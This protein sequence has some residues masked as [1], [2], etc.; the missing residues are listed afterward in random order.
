M[1]CC[2]VFHTYVQAAGKKGIS[3]V[4]HC[5]EGFRF[6]CLQARVCDYEDEGKMK[7]IPWDENIPRFLR[8]V[9]QAGVQFCPFCGVKLE[10]IISQ[11]LGDFDNLAKTHEQLLL[12]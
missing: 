12:K 4:A 5:Q 9:E 3:I 2:S 6:Y 8:L 1:F 11:H 10:N 7:N